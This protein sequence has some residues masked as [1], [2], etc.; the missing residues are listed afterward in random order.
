[1]DDLVVFGETVEEGLQ[2]FELHEVVAFVDGFVLADGV[3]LLPQ[4]LI[5]VE[6]DLLGDEVLLP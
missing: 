5:V 6:V 4:L 2:F 1:M 3:A